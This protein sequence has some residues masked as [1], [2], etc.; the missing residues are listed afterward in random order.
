MRRSPSHPP[1]TRPCCISA[2]RA[3]S[4]Q[5]G[6]KRHVGGSRGRTRSWYP[7]TTSAA[8]CPAFMREP[9]LHGAPGRAPPQAGACPRSARETGGWPHSAARPRPSRHPR[10]S[11]REPGGMPRGSAVARD[12]DALLP[13]AAGSPRTPLAASPPAATGRRS[14]AVR[15]GYHVGRPPGILPLAGGARLEAAITPPELSPPWGAKR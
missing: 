1:R 7:R 9:C 6:T 5:P 13:G 8:S 4:E 10:P 15:A 12:C 11:A 2:S 3:Y 14:S